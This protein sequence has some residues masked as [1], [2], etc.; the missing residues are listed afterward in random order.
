M[1]KAKGKRQVQITILYGLPGS[2]KSFYA[3]KHES[4][5]PIVDFD[6]IIK[7]SGL[8]KFAVLS[9][10]NAK[11]SG[12]IGSYPRNAHSVIIDGLVTTNQ[13][14]RDM[15]DSITAGITQYQVI[16]NLI[17]WNE[18]R[19]SCAY[20]DLGRRKVSSLTS[21]NNL[22]YEKPKLGLFPELSMKRVQVMK[23]IK[24]SPAI[25]WLADVLKKL[26]YNDFKAE[27]VTDSMQLKSARW[28]LGGTWCSWDDRSGDV[29]AEEPLEFGEFDRL[30]KEVC[31]NI[32]YLNCKTLK[33]ECC[34]ILTDGEGD[35]YGGWV[36]YNRHVCDLQKFFD[37][38]KEMGFVNDKS[39]L[40]SSSAS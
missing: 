37:C 15:I 23:V 38:L 8:N 25:I 7:S 17:Y 20:N 31:P 32:S 5:T 6:A 3:K 40:Q 18:D 26:A 30:I 28:S 21:I 2:G 27:S 29:D 4:S 24:R 11:I 16:F 39:T 22:P 34:T 36:T 35:Y 19:E 1:S 13:Q 9:S 33:S 12:L 10:L 14:L